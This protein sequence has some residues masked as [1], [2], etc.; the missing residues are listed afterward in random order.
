MISIELPN[1]KCLQESHT[2]SI[3]KV[4]LN[5]Q[6]TEPRL[7][8]KQCIKKGFHQQHNEEVKGLNSLVDFIDTNNKLCDSICEKISKQG[9]L[10]ME[11][12]FKIKNEIKN[13]HQI[14]KE[15]FL[16]MDINQMNKAINQMFSLQDYKTNITNPIED[17]QAEVKQK[18]DKLYQ[19]LS[20]RTINFSEVSKDDEK[21][22]SNLYNKGFN[23]FNSQEFD[24]AL[25][26]I[27]QTLKLN[28]NNKDSLWCKGECLIMK[29][30]LNEALNCYNQA[31]SVDPKHLNSIAAKGD[32]LRGLGQF[33]EAIILYDQALSINPKHIDSLYGK[34]D[35][36][37][38][39]GK[40]EESL[41]WL[42]Q[43]LSI[44]PQ[45]Y[46]SLQSKGVCLQELKKF[47]DALACYNQALKISSVDQFLIMR[48]NKCEEALKNK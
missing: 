40:F 45:D 25:K 2:Q 27:N 12:F 1:I 8:C 20:I 16:K 14:Q 48:K 26:V 46:F 28:P 24:E 4:C 41:K 11:A 23:L 32:C 30:N 43:A 31:I 36:L 21:S 38:E 17:L 3:S 6:C 9:D 18:I 37:R 35:C 42:N 7:I 39:Q 22:S 5:K 10:I 47:S 15:R 44:Q 13:K 19:Q 33:N 29:N 34:G